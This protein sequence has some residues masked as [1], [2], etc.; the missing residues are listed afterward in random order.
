MVTYSLEVS[1]ALLPH[2]PELIQDLDELGSDASV[3]L[4]ALRDLGVGPRHGVADLGCGNGY[5]S[6]KVAEALGCQVVG[7][8]LFAPFLAM[9]EARARQ[10]DVSQLC[11]FVHGDLLETYEDIAPVDVAIAASLGDVLGDLGQTVAAARRFV[12]VGGSMIVS[13]SFLRDG[14]T[15]HP[16]RPHGFRDHAE[17]L[18]LLTSWGDAIVD[19]RVTSSRATR[20]SRFEAE[21]IRRRAD[22]LGLRFPELRG[23]LD[24]FVEAQSAENDYVGANFLDAVWTLRRSA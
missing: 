15:R 2:V 17:T 3:I 10:A 4:S 19:E 7:I 21:A 13:E 1:H 12:R 22:G 5:V 23:E 20:S 16:S 8:D 24:R 11:R 6:V 14:A 18:R 9:C